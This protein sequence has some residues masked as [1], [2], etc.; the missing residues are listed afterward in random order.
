[1]IEYAVISRDKNFH[2]RKDDIMKPTLLNV[3][4]CK[5]VKMIQAPGAE[6]MLWCKIYGL[7][8]YG[9][10]STTILVVEILN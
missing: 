10:F 9:L 8:D 1:M 3:G 5:D 4:R 2:H 7:I 6:K